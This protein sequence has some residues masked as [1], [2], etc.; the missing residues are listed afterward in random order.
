MSTRKPTI[1]DVARLAG[2]STATVSYV[3]N[4]TP[5]KKISESTRLKVLDAV[6]KL[7]FTPSM[8]ARRMKIEGV[9]NICFMYSYTLYE[10][11]V[12]NVLKGI[13]DF[14]HARNCLV[15]LYDIDLNSYD[16]SYIENFKSHNIDGVVFF[17]PLIIHSEQDLLF[18]HRHLSN[19]ISA[20]I[21]VTIINGRSNFDNVSYVYMD[22]YHTGYK[23]VEYLHSLGH[24]EIAIII[25]SNN[26]KPFST[27]NNE[28]IKGI[29]DG[30]DSFI[31]NDYD[32]KIMTCEE[33]EEMADKEPSSLPQAVIICLMSD[34]GNV[35][36]AL[37]KSGI[38]IPE[39][40]SI[41]CA[42]HS[43]ASVLSPSLTIAYI[44]YEELGSRAAELLFRLA[45]SKKGENGGAIGCKIIAAESCTKRSGE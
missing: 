45:K 40:I 42:N 1:K 16:D 25:P 13:Q 28:R 39:D 11:S 9:N 30:I 12:V 29:I 33:L 43:S 2:I 15:T 35:Y 24:T 22:F 31:S 38:R 3:I 32:I 37:M 14:A 5:N 26:G 36:S 23:S 4:N 21:P 20:N 10:S 44:E 6:N 41:I 27:P 34:S 8:F 17:A 18:E 7:N 19:L